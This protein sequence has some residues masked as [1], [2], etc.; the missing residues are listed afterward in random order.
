MVTFGLHEGGCVMTVMTETVLFIHGFL[1][2]ATVW[3]GVIAALPDKVDVI[4]YDLPGS[5]TRSKAL[6]DPGTVTLESLAAEA[7]DIVAGTDP[8]VIVV[9]HSMGSQVAELVAAVHRDRV[10]G[11]VL[12]TPVPLG[13]TQLTAEVLA[14]FRALGGNTDAQRTL[15]SQVSPNLGANKLDRLVR[16]G[17]AVRPDVAARYVDMWNEGVRNA[18]ATSA[19]TGPVLIVRGGADAFVTEQVLAATTSRFVQPNVKVIDKGGH[20]LHVE[21]PDDLATTILGFT[22]TITGVAA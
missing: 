7:G 22:G 2:D 8:P 1:D 17:G 4:Q 10:Q 6:A 3:D 14:P 13:G 15:R 9:G 5:G 11:L 20:W 21:Y 18:P 19:F 16:I 12:I